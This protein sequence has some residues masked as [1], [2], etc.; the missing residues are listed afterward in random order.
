MVTVNTNKKC[1][2]MNL[3]MILYW[4][5]YYRK[6]QKISDKQK[7]CCKYS[8]FWTM[9]LDTEMCPK[10]NEGKEQSDRVISV[11]SDLSVWI[12]RIITYI[13]LVYQ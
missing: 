4:N 13:F 12:F 5:L 11:C 9:F 8:K 10:D 3:E 2:I 1:Y 6:Y 7:Y